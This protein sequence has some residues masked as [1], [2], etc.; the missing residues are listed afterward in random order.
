MVEI[1]YSKP[2]PGK[3]IRATTKKQEVVE[4][5]KPTGQFKIIG[6]TLVYEPI[7]K[8]YEYNEEKLKI[9]KTIVGCSLFKIYDTLNI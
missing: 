3:L 7:D 8:Y 2:E 6:Q 1:L 5:E 4:D 9:H